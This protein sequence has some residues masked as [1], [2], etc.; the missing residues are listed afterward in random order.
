MGKE[1]D[2][3]ITRIKEFNQTIFLS[4]LHSQGNQDL[5]QY[6]LQYMRNETEAPKPTQD[7][8]EVI[9]ANLSRIATKYTSSNQHSYY[10]E[11]DRTGVQVEVNKQVKSFS[12]IFSA[13][14]LENSIN[15]TKI[16][17]LNKITHRDSNHLSRKFG[18]NKNRELTSSNP[19]PYSDNFFSYLVWFGVLSNT[20]NHQALDKM[21]KSISQEDFLL[22]VAHTYNP[23]GAKFNMIEEIWNK[24]YPNHQ[25]T[26]LQQ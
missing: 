18:R 26:I 25:V 23:L 13:K 21:Y 7:E 12:N 9:T 10:N 2:S 3:R 14:S 24:H 16:I 6:L 22:D 5:Q 17:M 4:F 19:N 1:S 20:T 15:E 8:L 11:S